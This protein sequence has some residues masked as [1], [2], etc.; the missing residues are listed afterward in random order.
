MALL[1][2]SP[3]CAPLLGVAAASRAVSGGAGEPR[4]AA[5]DADPGGRG[6]GGIGPKAAALQAAMIPRRAMD[7]GWCQRLQRLTARWL[8]WTGTCSWPDLNHLDGASGQPLDQPVRVA[9]SSERPLLPPTGPGPWREAS[10]PSRRRLIGLGQQ[11][12]HLDGARCALAVAQ[13]FQRDGVMTR[14]SRPRG[15]A[16]LLVPAQRP[17]RPAA[18]LLQSSLRAPRAQGSGRFGFALPP[19][20]LRPVLAPGP[21]PVAQPPSPVRSR[22]GCC[23]RS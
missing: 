3:G 16:P 4:W 1:A 5:F 14:A 13:G 10:H 6:R 9:T 17:V 19:L 2:A 8:G 21:C 22:P 7:W 23:L 18:M 20:S 15:S 12:C 11:G